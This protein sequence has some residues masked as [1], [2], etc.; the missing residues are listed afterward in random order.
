MQYLFRAKRAG[1]V[2]AMAFF[3]LFLTLFSIL[4]SL[5]LAVGIGNP[6]DKVTHSLW[7]SQSLKQ[8]AG[9][10]LVSKT[11]E[12]ATGEERKLLLKKGPQISAAVTELLGNPLLHQQIDLISNS[13]Y[14]YY[15]SGSKSEVSVDFRPIVRLA[16]ENLK[17]ID[18]QFSSAKSEIDKIDPIRLQVQKDGPNISQVKTGLNLAVIL[19]LILSL[20]MLFLYAIFAKALKAALRWVGLIVFLEGALLT[21]VYLVVDSLIAHQ[22]SISTESL[23]REA[24]PLATHP[25][26][27][28]FLTCGIIEL[29]IGL[30]L[31]IGSFL[32]RKKLSE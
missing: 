18:P 19:L 2:P 3:V 4:G 6:I 12:G 1:S 30:A 8:N 7:E 31:F 10:Y 9:K 27:A 13:V 25:L 15:T 22:A 11:L 16:F 5:F 26:I 29:L 17:F 24:L 21:T 20:L 32:M 23:A 28:P 14:V